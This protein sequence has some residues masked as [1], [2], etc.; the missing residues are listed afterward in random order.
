[1]RRRTVTITFRVDNSLKKKVDAIKAEGY[2]RLTDILEHAIES[3]HP[4]KPKS[5]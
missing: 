5:N 3:Y 4:C 1:M 2:G